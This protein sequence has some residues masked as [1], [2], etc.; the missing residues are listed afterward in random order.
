MK[1]IVLV[2]AALGALFIGSQSARAA[3]VYDPAYD[4]SGFFIGLHAGYAWGDFDYNSVGAATHQ[5][6]DFTNALDK[7]DGFVGGFTSGY[8]FQ[9][10]SFVLGYESSFSIADVNDDFVTPDPEWHADLDWY[11]L[12]RARFGWAIDNVMPFIA[13]GLA[14]GSIEVSAFDNV[15]P[16]AGTAK[17]TD[18]NFGWTIG[19]GVEWGVTENISV[20]AEYAYV[21][22]GSSKYNLS[23]NAFFNTERVDLDM[24]VV[25]VG[26]NW[27]F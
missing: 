21:D 6:D 22:F 20:K 15:V 23:D 12:H 1:K 5:L 13:G 7:A 14:V 17:D 19:G 10:G 3:D 8:N 26:V 4:W 25:R 16:A 11:S 9:T 27:Q 2:S 24:H 18:L